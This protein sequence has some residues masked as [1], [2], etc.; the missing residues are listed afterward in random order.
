MTYIC[1]QC[2]KKET[3]SKSWA[4][5]LPYTKDEPHKHDWS[6]A[7]VL[8]QPENPPQRP[9]PTHERFN[10]R[11]TQMEKRLDELEK[12]VFSHLGKT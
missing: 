3:N 12:A 7:L 11:G 5:S 6:H 8:C 10:A 2:N 9:K 4:L 1:T